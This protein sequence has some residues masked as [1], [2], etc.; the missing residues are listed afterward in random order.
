VVSVRQKKWM[1][2]GSKERFFSA[3]VGGGLFAYG[4]Y[5]ALPPASRRHKIFG[6][7]SGL[8]GLGVLVRGFSGHSIAYS[9]LGLSTM[10]PERAKH[11]NKIT[12]ALTIHRPIDE[13]YAEFQYASR[14][15]KAFKNLEWSKKESPSQ[16]RIYTWKLRG[17]K[18]SAYTGEVK[19]TEEKENHLISWESLPD[20]FPALNVQLK[21]EMRFRPAPGDRGT[22]VILREKPQPSANLLTK[23]LIQSLYPISEQILRESA[24]RMKQ[25]IETGEIATTQGQPEG[26]REFR[27]RERFSEKIDEANLKRRA[28][29]E[30]GLL[31]G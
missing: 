22:Q 24:R 26:V 8:T 29:D 15:E 3:S 16:E 25:L 2:V 14:L 20:S 10:N 12:V 31:A 7:I 18:N 28:K 17:P 27:L 13:V 5:R 6:A 21:G 1:N 9:R 11:K 19:V 23:A 30:G 4:L